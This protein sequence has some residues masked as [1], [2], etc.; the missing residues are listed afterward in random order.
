MTH[1]NGHVEPLAEQPQESPPAT[2]GTRSESLTR[3]QDGYLKAIAA[4]EDRNE[5]LQ[6]DLNIAQPYCANTAQ[7]A[8]YFEQQ[9][10]YLQ[11]ELG[12]ARATPDA[13]KAHIV[14]LEATLAAKNTRIKEKNS[15]IIR[16]E[17]NNR[18]L[19]EELKAERSKNKV[20]GESRRMVPAVGQTSWDRR[21]IGANGGG[22][23]LKK[24]KLVEFVREGDYDKAVRGGKE[25]PR[26]I[27]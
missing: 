9:N 1:R 6:Q 3:L 2:N 15:Q 11:L 26:V 22:K 14:Q 27:D 5:S 21:G 23:A 17:Q 8:T 20:G 13:R 19:E 16:L 10:G 7:R 12:A 24:R 18:R 25:D 4:L